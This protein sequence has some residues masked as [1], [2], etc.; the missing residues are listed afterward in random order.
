MITEAEATWLLS[1]RPLLSWVRAWAGSEYALDSHGE[2][3]GLLLQDEGSER[4]FP[5]VN[6][7]TLPEPES[8]VVELQPGLAVRQCDD[9][10]LVGLLQ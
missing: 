6:H 9:Q 4:S 10:F 5:D 8:A 3:A 2:T 7:V 1:V